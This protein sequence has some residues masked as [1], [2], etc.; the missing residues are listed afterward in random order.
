MVSAEKEKSAK[1]NVTDAY[2]ADTHSIRQVIKIQSIWRGYQVRK[3][4]ISKNLYDLAVQFIQQNP[5]MMGVPRAASGI[6]PVYLPNLLPVVLKDLG[7]GRVSKRFCYMWEARDLCLR[8]GYNH[9][10]IPRAHPYAH[11]N[12]EER[13]PVH[14]VTQREQIALYEDNKE[15][16]SEAVKDFTGFLCQSVFPDI[17]T[18]THPYLQKTNIPLGRCDNLPLL[19]REGVGQIALIDLGGLKI[20]NGK[21]AIDEAIEAALAAIYIFP[22]HF[23]E[24]LGVVHSFC[25]EIDRELPQLEEVCRQTLKGFKSIYADHQEFIQN[26]NQGLD[27]SLNWD[28][29]VHQ[30]EEFNRMMEG[31][32][33]QISKRVME[34]PILDFNQRMLTLK[35]LHKGAEEFINQVTKRLIDRKAICYANLFY[36]R[37]GEMF[38]RVHY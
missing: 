20:K 12:I 6:T 14:E 7:E 28:L 29:P 18:Y 3:G 35:I 26:Q 10:L 17:L 37:S 36:K 1:M 34:H 13:L 16:F 38:L 15:R 21:L 2:K 25:P 30:N 19:I 8:N 22:Y 9:L 31:I 11:F 5:A 33:S 23:D 4:F 27:G 32:L 24:I